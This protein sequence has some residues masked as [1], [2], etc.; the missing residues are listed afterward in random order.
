[1][2]RYLGKTNAWQMEP[3]QT[4]KKTHEPKT[5]MKTKHFTQSCFNN[6]NQP[7]CRYHKLKKARIDH[8]C[9]LESE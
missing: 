2:E 5:A 6:E 7:L 9:P 3:L 1:M 4:N 8:L